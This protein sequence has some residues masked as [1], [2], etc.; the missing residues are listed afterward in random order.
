MAHMY[1]AMQFGIYTAAF[2]YLAYRGGFWLDNRFNQYPL[3]TILCILAA[4]VYSFL[5]LYHKLRLIEEIK[6]KNKMNQQK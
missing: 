5:S 2:I 6:K 4:V 1:I 3:F